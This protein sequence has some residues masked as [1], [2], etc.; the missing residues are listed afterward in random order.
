[1]KKLNLFRNAFFKNLLFIPL[2]IC[3]LSSLLHAQSENQQKLSDIFSTIEAAEPNYKSSPAANSVGTFSY[4]DQYSTSYGAEANRPWNNSNSETEVFMSRLTYTHPTNDALSFTASLGEGGAIYSFRN[5]NGEC[6]AKQHGS[7]SNIHD[8]D[9]VTG[10]GYYNNQW[11]EA[12]WH[13]VCNNIEYQGAYNAATGKDKIIW[14]QGGAY[15]NL[16][17]VTDRTPFYGFQIADYYNSATEEYSTVAW[18]QIGHP[19]ATSTSNFY[20]EVLVWTKYRNVGQGVLQVD[21]ALYNFGDHTTAPPANSFRTPEIDRINI[22]YSAHN[23]Q[24]HNRL[25]ESISGGGYTEMTGANWQSTSSNSATNGW[26]AFIA[27]PNQETSGTTLG[28][29]YGFI[30][31]SSAGSNKFGYVGATKD[32][33]NFTSIRTDVDIFEGDL[34]SARYFIKVGG[35]ISAI[36]S[37]GATY[38][39]DTQHSN[40]DL[41]K[42]E[43]DD[44]E[45]YFNVSGN[46]ITASNATGDSQG[47]DLKLQPYQNSYPLFIVTNSSGVSKVTSDLYAAVRAA[48]P[49]E[50]RPWNGVTADVKLLGFADNRTEVTTF[51]TVSV[52]SGGS[53]TFPDNTTINNITSDLYQLSYTGTSGGYDQYEQTFVDV[54]GSSGGSGTNLALNGTASQSST[55]TNVGGEASLANDGNTN[56][57]WGGGS[58]TRTNNETNPWWEV[59]LGGTYTIE[60]VNIFGRTDGCCND[61]LDDYNVIVYAANGSIV[62]QEQNITTIP[63]PSHSVNVGGVNGRT[64]RIQQNDAN[65]LNLAEVQVIE[66]SSSSVAVTGASVLPSSATLTSAGATQSLSA[67]ISP[68]NATNQDV[69]WSSSNNGVATVNSSG[70]VTAVA[71]GSATITATTSDGGFTDTS[72]I[73]VSISTGSE[74]IGPWNITELKQTPNWTTTNVSSVAGM[75]GILYESI[76]YQG[77]PVEV[78]AYYSA[79]AGT[80]PAGGWPAAIFVSGG[81]GDAFASAVEYW[82]DRG[83]AA[84]SMD[85]WGDFPDGSATPNPGPNRSGVFN[86]WNLPN[87]EDQWYYH[88]VAQVM[89]AHSLIASFSE[90]NPNKIGLIGASWGGNLTGTVMGLD[91]RLAWALPIYGCGYLA[92]SDGSQGASIGTGDKADFVT[93]NFDGSAYFNNV[94]FPTFFMNRTNDG[95]FA[96]SCNQQSSQAVQGSTG[97]LYIDTGFGHGNENWISYEEPYTFAESVV[98]GGD[99][100][101]EVGTPYISSGVGSL[102]VT[103]SVGLSGARLLYTNDGD[104]VELNEKTWLSVTANISGNTVSASIPGT[105]ELI[106]FEVTDSRGLRKTSEYLDTDDTTPPPSNGDNLALNGTAT[107]STTVNGAEASR[108]IDGDTNGNFSGGSV[109]AAQGPNAWW[110]VN[111]GAEYNIDDIIIFNRTN[112]CCTDRLSDFTVSVIDA[113]GTTTYS[114][115]IT[116]EPSPSVTID[117]LGTVG[118]VIRVQ[119]NLTSTMN[120][121]E[122]EVFGSSVQCAGFSTIEAEGFNNMSNVVVESTSDTGGGQHVGFIENGEWISFNNMDLTCATS[123]QARVSCNTSGGDIEVRLG[124]V[125]GTLIGTIPVSNTGGWNSWTTL[126]NTNLTPTSGTHEVYLVFTGGSGYLLNLNWLEFSVGQQQTSLKST[127]TITLGEPVTDDAQNRFVVY[128]NPA[129]NSITIDFKSDRIAKIEI[130]GSLGETIRSGAIENGTKT[131]DLSGLSSGLYIIKVSDGIETFTKKILKK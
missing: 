37:A 111:L 119:S 99:P 11:C 44:A 53:V 51:S 45:Y 78:F 48:N 87:I 64:V 55:N 33:N 13:L 81:N 41:L 96:M 82:N 22:P 18:L 43:T 15:G 31:E 115:T 61:R 75:T 50:L 127:S 23:D 98:N 4:T 84:I 71:N 42:S 100:L 117:A 83:Y 114:Q 106:I 8:P 107:Q 67:T 56:G 80:P 97:L 105:A 10:I 126:T 89:R 28:A 49:N 73:T 108:A 104:A 17:T 88:A 91:N 19:K 20:S 120:I 58:V 63:N 2:L 74:Y 79:P 102:T 29:G 6:I 12:V 101:P 77:N 38:K 35:S 70:V 60:T 103:S 52:N 30:F 110:E 27:G 123:V 112:S 54:S 93:A 24:T 66:A 32:Q 118:Q 65:I 1:M 57:S 16:D 36:E 86:D 9:P 68:S 116:T 95:H 21:Q 59:D 69:N 122:V 5:I 25:F 130:V 34:M 92:G 125:S 129:S 3:G 72:N 14:H 26:V 90:V 113:N 7:G 121:A 40:W 128:P 94:T 109:I 124:G 131:V 46:T 62:W 47:L 76:P 85:T 39:D